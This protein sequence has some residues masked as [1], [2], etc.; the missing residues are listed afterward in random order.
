M[1]SINNIVLRLYLHLKIYKK[2]GIYDI[3]FYLDITG[4]CSIKSTRSTGN[5]E[6]K[7]ITYIDIAMAR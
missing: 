5:I 6:I 4:S 1:V 3:W 2:K 7:S